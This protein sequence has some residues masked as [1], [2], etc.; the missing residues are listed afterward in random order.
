MVFEEGYSN[1]LAFYDISKFTFETYDGTTWTDVTSSISDVDKKKLVG[2]DANS[3]AIIPNGAQKYRITIRNKGSYVFISSL[4]M[5]AS[6]QGNPIKIHIWKKRDDGDWIQA[7]NSDTEVTGWPG[8]FF[9][10]FIYIPWSLSSTADYYHEIRIEI[11]P[12]WNNTN[13]ILLYKLQL[14]G[15]YPA[16]KRRVYSVDE[17]RNVTF[18]ANIAASGS[19]DVTGAA[20]ISTLD[21]TGATT[22]DDT[23][24]VSGTTTIDDTLSVSGAATIGGTL[25]VSGATTISSLDVSGATTIGGTLTVNGSISQNGSWQYN[26]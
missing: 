3:G 6:T 2:G 11:T 23:L 7:T 14:W 20:T 26:S 18:P 15:S 5:Y 9:L 21:V 16:E 10:P 12:T 1:K 8:H 17:D 24:D 13:N 4:Y 19:L 22:I 25:S